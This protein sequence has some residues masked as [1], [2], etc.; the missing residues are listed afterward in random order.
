MH[1]I[2]VR[3]MHFDFPDGIDPVVVE[4][5]P[6]ESYRLLGLSLL[7]PY[8]EPYLIRTMNEAK[9]RIDDPDLLKDLERFNAQEG[10]HYRQHRRLNE[11]VRMAGFPEAPRAGGRVGRRLPPFQ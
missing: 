5:Q 1:D 4:G 8:L 2:T 7:L 9:K 6:E 11:A 10:Q 3:R